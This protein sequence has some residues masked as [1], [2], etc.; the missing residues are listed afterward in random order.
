VVPVFAIY[1]HGILSSDKELSSIDYCG[2]L[3]G[4]CAIAN[5]SWV[6]IVSAITIL[7][8]Y[9]FKMYKKTS[10]EQSSIDIFFIASLVFL[11]AGSVLGNFVQLA[12]EQG[13]GDVSCAVSWISVPEKIAYIEKAMLALLVMVCVGQKRHWVAFALAMSFCNHDLKIAAMVAILFYLMPNISPIFKKILIALTITI[14]FAELLASLDEFNAIQS[15]P[16]QGHPLLSA[17]FLSLLFVFLLWI[18]MKKN[19]ANGKFIWVPVFGTILL[20]C[21]WN[22]CEWDARDDSQA[23]CERQMDAFFETPLFQQVAD[24]GKILFAVENEAPMQSRI[25][26]LTG[27]FADASIYVGEV[28]YY[29]Q[30]KE[31]NRR[32]SMLLRGDSVLTDMTNFEEKIYSIYQNPDTLFARVGY[33]CRAGEITHFVTDKLYAA[34]PKLDSTYLDVR[35]IAVYL[36]G[37]PTEEKM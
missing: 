20:F 8:V 15:T 37:C 1:L 17:T 22:V 34:L 19:S 10:I 16:L 29:N 31:S 12:L 5:E 35:K 11:I 3:L 6:Y 4:M 23:D 32:R 33:L 24:R 25:N 27:A 18:L 36:Y 28:F 26:F 13:L 14:S 21:W 2:I 30:Y 7:A 9:L